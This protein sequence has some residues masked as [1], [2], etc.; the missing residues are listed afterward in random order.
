M[1]N[2]FKS[3]VFKLLMGVIAVIVFG[4]I[5]AAANGV[6]EAAQST[7]VGTIFSPVQRAAAYVGEKLHFTAGNITG[8]TS[9]E[10]KIASLHEEIGALQEQLVDYENVKRQNTLYKEF[11]ELKEERADFEFA[12]CAVI[13]RDSADL[14]YSFTVNKGTKDGV[15]VND[16]VIYGKYLVGVVEK[17]YPTYAVVRT[18]LDPEFNASVYELVSQET[19]YITGT[20]ELARQGETKMAS[21]TSSTAVSDGSLICTTG[22]GGVFPKDLI[23]GTVTD[24][25]SETVDISN[26]AVIEPG[27]DVRSLTDVFIITSFSGQ[28]E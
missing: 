9:Y 3:K 25:K 16:P 1:L 26:Y 6:G 2:F 4:M 8:R 13:G 12:E 24:I 17:A 10:E 23:L 21:L 18:I 20:L 7:V 22:V 14:F 27:V 15:K 19:G 11:L 28:G 5:V